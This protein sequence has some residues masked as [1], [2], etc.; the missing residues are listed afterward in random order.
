MATLSQAQISYQR[1]HIKD[2]RS[3]D[4]LGTS[5]SMAVLSIVAVIGRLACRKKMKVDLSYDDYAI[6]LGLVRMEKTIYMN[7]S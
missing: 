2:D 7:N 6:L 1:K 3:A 4:L 5:I